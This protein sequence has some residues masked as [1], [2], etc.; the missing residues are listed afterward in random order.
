MLFFL[1]PGDRGVE[2]SKGSVAFLEAIEYSYV[3]SL[4][5]SPRADK[6][7]SR[8][9]GSVQDVPYATLHMGQQRP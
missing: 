4:S 3:E 2:R 1:C 6:S 5:Q 8:T 9:D 7:H